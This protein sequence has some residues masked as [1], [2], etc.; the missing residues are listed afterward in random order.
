[1]SIVRLFD[2]V[3]ITQYLESVDSGIRNEL[4]S[5]TSRI[6]ST[7][8]ATLA[9]QIAN[10][11]RIIMPVVDF[12]SAIT[13]VEPVPERGLYSV[14]LIDYVTYE[15]NFS[16]DENVLSCRPANGR[17]HIGYP[18]EVGVEDSK[19]KFFIKSQGSV[20]NEG[21]PREQVKRHAQSIKDYIDCSL[22]SLKATIDEW[23]KNLENLLYEGISATREYMLNVEE[24]RRSMED[25]LNTFKKG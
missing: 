20:R 18:V 16:G 15:I 2:E 12:K 11:H 7:D 8:S 10:K 9:M 22:E 24:S 1:M 6:Q 21:E 17:C 13:A 5:L 19:I 4:R 14:V 3:S 23:N 25:D